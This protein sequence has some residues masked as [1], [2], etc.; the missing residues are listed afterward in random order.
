MLAMNMGTKYVDNHPYFGFDSRKKILFRVGETGVVVLAALPSAIEALNIRNDFFTGMHGIELRAAELRGR[1]HGSQS[2]VRELTAAE[3][4]DAAVAIYYSNMNLAERYS[5][6]GSKETSAALYNLRDKVLS[7]HLPHSKEVLEVIVNRLPTY[8]QKAVAEVK[9]L[10]HPLAAKAAR[11]VKQKYAEARLT[12]KD[13]LA[14]SEFTDNDAD[15]AA[16]VLFNLS[17]NTIVTIGDG[18]PTITTWNLGSVVSTS[19]DIYTEYRLLSDTVQ[20]EIGAMPVHGARELIT[21][22]YTLLPRKTQDHLLQMKSQMYAEMHDAASPWIYL[23][24]AAVA[25]RVAAGRIFG[26]K[27]KNPK[28]PT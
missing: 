20:E 3:T 1:L 25:A 4:E 2:S 5:F 16:T 15:G 7:H 13:Y 21:T 27:G 24:A 23:I 12:L 18:K 11:E 6:P 28:S 22:Y 10:H 17:G 19:E 14:Q 8:E 26:K 9:G